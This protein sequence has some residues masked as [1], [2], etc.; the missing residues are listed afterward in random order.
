MEI[1]ATTRARRANAGANMSKLLD[2]EEAMAAEDDF[3][4]TQYGGFDEVYDLVGLI[5]FDAKKLQFLG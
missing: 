1:I 4:K 3:C 5:I 2:K